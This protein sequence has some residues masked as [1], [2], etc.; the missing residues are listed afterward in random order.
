M[1]TMSNFLEVTF[2]EVEKQVIEFFT[3]IDHEISLFGSNK[4]NRRRNREVQGL[5][6]TFEGL[7]D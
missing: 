4:E 3:T 2:D 5:R 1:Q 6:S 7:S